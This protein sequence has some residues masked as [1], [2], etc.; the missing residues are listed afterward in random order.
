MSF[1]K[2][3]TELDS[4]I[5]GFYLGDTQALSALSKVSK[6]YRAIT[7][8]FLYAEIKTSIYDRYRMQDLLFTVMDREDLALYIKNVK[9]SGDWHEQY[10]EPAIDLKLVFWKRA[11]T[12]W[13]KLDHIFNDLDSETNIVETKYMLYGRLFSH[14]LQDS[15]LALV[16]FFAKKVTNL[17]LCE[18]DD[19]HLG[20]L[21]SMLGT[22]WSH[23]SRLFECLRSLDTRGCGDARR[24]LE[25][26]VAS[27]TTVNVVRCNYIQRRGRP[28]QSGFLWHASPAPFTPNLRTVTF[29]NV[30]LTMNNPKEFITS[31]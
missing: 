26:L 12:L 14:S 27:M 15:A 20:S 29:N 19:D 23:R 17:T 21:Q 1:A 9:I 28:H 30:H 6:Y 13:Y 5:A 2:L 10:D 4:K 8:P 18:L 31:P 16:L 3:S 22:N 11:H 24:S 7:E 25:F